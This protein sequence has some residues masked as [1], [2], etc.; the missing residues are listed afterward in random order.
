MGHFALFLHG[1]SDQGGKIGIID[2]I[3]EVRG[4]AQGDG[5]LAG[6][7]GD[8]AIFLINQQKTGLRQEAPEQLLDDQALFSGLQD[9]GFFLSDHV[10]LEPDQ[11]IVQRL[12]EYAKLIIRFRQ[13]G[14]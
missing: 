4:A 11:E 3:Q 2:E 1:R 6:A 9:R 13:I 7:V 12:V 8:H 10:G 5:G 14:F